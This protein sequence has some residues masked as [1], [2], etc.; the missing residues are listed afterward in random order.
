P[1]EAPPSDAT[2]GGLPRRVRQANL[3]PQLKDGPDLRG[4]RTTGRDETSSAPP[5]D[6]D[7]DEV[8]SRMASLQRGWRRGRAENAADDESA[9]GTAQGTTSEGDGR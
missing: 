9:D 1:A 5:A 6:R 4:D 8:R 2:A 7:A 3:A